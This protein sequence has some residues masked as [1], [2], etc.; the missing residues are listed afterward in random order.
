MLVS[1]KTY[2]L[3][4]LILRIEH[5]DKKYIVVVVTRA[6]PIYQFADI[7]NQYWPIA[8]I[9]VSAHTFCKNILVN[10]ELSDAN[11]G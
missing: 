9:L 1:F 2:G 5:N 7:I 10:C 3:K 4:L 8:N 6:R 11:T